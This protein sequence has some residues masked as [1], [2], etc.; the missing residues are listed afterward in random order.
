MFRKETTGGSKERRKELTKE[1]NGMPEPWKNK[2]ET[3]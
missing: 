1:D 3:I 2:E